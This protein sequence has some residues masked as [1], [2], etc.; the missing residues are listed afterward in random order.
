MEPKLAAQ[1]TQPC[2]ADVVLELFSCTLRLEGL[3]GLLNQQILCESFGAREALA[4]TPTVVLP[5]T[6]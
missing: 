5:N 4:R 6:S 3:V 1:F 2:T